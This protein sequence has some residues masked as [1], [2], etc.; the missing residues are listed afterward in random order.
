V[1]GCE[2]VERVAGVEQPDRRL[3]HRCG[4]CEPGGGG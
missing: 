4:D 3:R 1:F 2:E